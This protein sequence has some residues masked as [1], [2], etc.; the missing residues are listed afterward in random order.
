MPSPAVTRFG[1][2][3]EKLELAAMA[4]DNHP[5]AILWHAE[6]HSVEQPHLDDVIQSLQSCRESARNTSDCCKE[7]RERFQ[8]PKSSVEPAS[9]RK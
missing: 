2:L 1:L 3:I 7:H 5:L 4:N 6:V 9:R 8:K